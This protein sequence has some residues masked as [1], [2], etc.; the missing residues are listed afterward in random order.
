[1]GKSSVATS[2]APVI[3]GLFGLFGG[4]GCASS[5]PRLSFAVDQR[6]LRETTLDDLP[7]DQAGPGDAVVRLVRTGRAAGACSGAL[8]GPRHVLTAQHC[9]VD[10]DE[11]KELSMRMLTPGEM[12]VELGGDYLPWGRVGVREVLPCEGYTHDLEH[13]IAMVVLSKPVPSV[14]G[15]FELS[16]DVPLDA[17]VFELAGFGTSEKARVIPLT[18]WSISSVTRHV[19]HGPVVVAGDESLFVKIDGAPGDSGGPIID[20]ATGRIVSVVSRGISKKESRSG[21]PLV[22]GP[23][24]TT[25]RHAIEVAL[26]R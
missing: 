23:R 19:N 1:V 9:V 2:L 21:E 17:G 5:Y 20:T 16:W 15:A 7:D 24:L 11:H 22:A 10:L 8:V 12:H 6:I 13:D 3:L 18:G 26:A 25:C 4:A 14:V